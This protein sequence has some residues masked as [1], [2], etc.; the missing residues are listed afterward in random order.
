MSQ[1]LV[2]SILDNE[3]LIGIFDKLG[4][5]S[6]CRHCKLVKTVI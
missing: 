6:F 3:S 4:Q 1:S 5:K 2:T